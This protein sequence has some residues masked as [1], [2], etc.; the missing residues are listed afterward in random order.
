M[1]KNPIFKALSSLNLAIFL[2]LTL[3]ATSIVGTLLPQGQPIHFYLQKYGPTLGKIIKFFHLYDAY[4]SWWYISLLSLFSLNLLLCS[5]K[6]FPFSLEL[7]RRNPFA[8]SLDKIKRMPVCEELHLKISLEDIRQKVTETI[9]QKLGSIK[10]I[11]LEE[12]LLLVKD[13]ARWSYFSVYAVHLSIFIILIGGIIGALWG[14]RGSIMLMEGEMTN[15]VI[16]EGKKR[17]FVSLPFEIRCDQFLIDFY[18]DGTPKEYRSDVTIL[19][20]GKEILKKSIK[21][22]APLT[23]KG[24][25][26]YQ[27]TYQTM[28]QASFKLIKD[29]KEKLFNIKPYQLGRWKD[30]GIRFG[31]MQFAQA[32][33]LP[34]VRIWLS[35]EDEPPRAFWLLARHPKRIMTKKGPLVI[36]L[37]EVKPVYVTGL[38]VKK[39]PGVWIVWI[40]F[41]FLI[42]GIFA[43]F[44]F[45]H[46]CYWIVLLPEKDNTK[47]ILSGMSPKNRQAIQRKIEEIK[48]ALKHIS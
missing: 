24:I 19:E 33:G 38:Q 15:K 3:A 29:S 35:L 8:V 40:G 44:F 9:T 27:A 42:L 32:H 41:S 6:R 10:T 45:T 11:S 26:F 30:E 39:D 14:F 17:K 48:E 1:F 12:G 7:Y 25:T 47:I 31:I 16:I 4:H 37:E 18:P 36:V 5:I 2:L 20:N 46:Q 13:K 43:T 23:H 28:A 21:V 34:A 22:N